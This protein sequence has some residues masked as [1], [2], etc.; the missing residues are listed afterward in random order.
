M[1]LVIDDEL[2][3]RNLAQKILSR[4]GYDV[5][6]AESGEDG[7]AVF[8]TKANEIKLAIID[9]SMDGLSGAETLRE[10]RKTNPGLPGVISTGHALEMADLPEEIQN[11][12]F[13]LM[14]PYRATEMVTQV[15]K[16]LSGAAGPVA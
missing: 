6:L 5:L 14:K 10:M 13:L 2:M 9:M 15:E 11:N 1:I 8:R 16:M 12:T 3:I 7:L 4:A